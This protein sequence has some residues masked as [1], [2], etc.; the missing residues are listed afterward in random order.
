MKIW[1]NP[2]FFAILFL[3]ILSTFALKGLA[4]PG[5]YTSHDGE[6]HVARIAQY[7]QALADGQIPPRLA[8]SFY[9]GLGSPIFVYIYPLPYL[10]GSFIHL[11]GFSFV[12]SF[13]I[14]M[15]LSFIF[16]GIFSYLWLREI[17]KSERAAFLGAI[18]YTW[19][20]Y[21]F[22]L[23]YVRASLS[24]TLAYTFLPL[25]FYSLTKLA[26]KQN[27]IWLTISALSLSA[28]LLSQNLVAA[29]TVPII[30][31][32]ILILSFKQHSARYFFRSL[33]A[34]IWGFAI[35][36]VTYLPSLLERQ[37]I[38]FDEIINIAYYDH[39]ASFWQLVRS[40]WGYGF[41]LSGTVNDQLSFQIGLAHLLI[42]TIFIILIVKKVIVRYLISR[43]SESF[44]NNISKSD[45]ILAIF[46][47]AVL[48]LSILL[49]LQTKLTVNIWQQVKLL[50]IIDIPWRLLG[51]VALALS[52]LAAFVVK[53]IK[54]GLFFLVLIVF[55]LVANRNHLRINQSI[56]FD[57]NHFDKFYGTATQY[58]EFT[59]KW[60][61]TT[62]TPIGFDPGKPI[63]IVAGNAQFSDI[64]AK[65]N[66]ISF[67]ADVKT[68]SQ[69]QINKF[70]FP[71]W[72]IFDNGHKI[73]QNEITITGPTNLDLARQRDNSGLMSFE[74]SEGSHKIKAKFSET[75][76]RIFANYL[77]FLSLILAIAVVLKNVKFIKSYQK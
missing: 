16:S 13:K 68:P 49:M 9:N 70:Y 28:L 50:Q 12:S 55:V 10:L 19:V 33:I 1:Y 15:M 71:N 64:L 6:T 61:Q 48:L 54:N 60:R 57:D 41:D 5:F 40:P 42:I 7:Y 59:P 65:S 62:R 26:S 21:R 58:D 4:Q 8:G 38:R 44:I 77:S 14:I 43:K 29:M 73:A 2:D 34:L 35:A 75:P 69:I 53:S 23:I 45:L 20:P 30:G 67:E 22:S 3:I 76:L 56:F 72:Q 25:V 46:F 74:L 11:L 47:F 18:F 27:L 32:Y 31:T 51:I 37:Y 52:F 66:Q 36:S 63:E 24:E 17:I 39:F